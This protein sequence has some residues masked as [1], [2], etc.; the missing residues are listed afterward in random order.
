[1]ATL[2][3]ARFTLDMDAYIARTTKLVD[4]IFSPH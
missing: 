2:D 1:M 4:T 3:L